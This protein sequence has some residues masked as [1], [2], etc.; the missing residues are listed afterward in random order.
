[1]ETWKKKRACMIGIQDKVGMGL[2]HFSRAAVDVAS[3]GGGSAK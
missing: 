2:M 1:M 3:V